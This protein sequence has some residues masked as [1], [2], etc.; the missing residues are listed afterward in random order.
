MAVLVVAVITQVGRLVGMELVVLFV[1]FGLA[2]PVLS[3]QQIQV[4]FNA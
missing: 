1:L 4:G 3:R 2:Q